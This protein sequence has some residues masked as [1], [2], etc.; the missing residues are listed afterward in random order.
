MGQQWQPQKGASHHG[1]MRLLPVRVKQRCL[2]LQRGQPR[3]SPPLA[4]WSGG[5]GTLPGLG[6]P[7]VTLR[8]CSGLLQTRHCRFWRRRN[9]EGSSRR[10]GNSGA[11]LEPP[12]PLLA[13]PQPQSPAPEPGAAFPPAARSLPE[14]GRSTE[15]FFLTLQRDLGTNF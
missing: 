10:P 14:A 11:G 4:A 7:T 12:P 13:V 9:S 2:Q 8:G 3:P 1:K 15:P 6:R 5:E